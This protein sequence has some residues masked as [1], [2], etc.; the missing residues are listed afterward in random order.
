MSPFGYLFMFTH[1]IYVSRKPG[2][3]LRF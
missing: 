3:I 2:H 1:T